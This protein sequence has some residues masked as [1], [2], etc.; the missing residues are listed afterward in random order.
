MSGMSTYAVLLSRSLLLVES[1]TVNAKTANTANHRPSADGAVM[2][3]AKHIPTASERGSNFARSFASSTSRPLNTRE[4]TLSSAQTM[5]SSDKD[6]KA[7]PLAACFLTSLIASA[8]S[9]RCSR[10]IFSPIGYCNARTSS[11]EYDPIKLNVS[12]SCFKYAANALSAPNAYS[13][14]NTSATRSAHFSSPAAFQSSSLMKSSCGFSCPSSTTSAAPRGSVTSASSTL[15][16][17]FA[18]TPRVVSAAS[19][20]PPTYEIS[21]E[22][23]LTSLAASHSA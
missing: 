3:V 20:A 14:N 8:F 17:F 21:S 1:K 10:A 4:R 11:S 16:F 19:A 5:R 23:P 7:P 6:A 12:G 18:T 2:K 13:R 9:S 15:M 22:S